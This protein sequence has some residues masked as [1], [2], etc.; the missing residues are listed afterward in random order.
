[1][2]AHRGPELHRSGAIALALASEPN[3]G[4]G[5]LP[6]CF[7]RLYSQAMSVEAPI[8]DAALMAAFEN[9]VLPAEA[10]NHRAHVRV[11]FTYARQIDPN[12]AVE[13]MRAGLHALNDAHRVPDVADR[14]YHETITVAFIRL[15]HAACRHQTFASSVEFCDCHPELMHK[16][17]L[18]HYYSRERLKSLEAKTTFVQPDLKPLP[19]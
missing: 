10:W 18:L 4:G 9:A 17:V 14:G 12:A 2:T 3:D 15:I 5:V 6:V 11:A 1:M 7:T 19:D 13:R 16:N 8:D